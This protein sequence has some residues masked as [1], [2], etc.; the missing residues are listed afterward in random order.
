MTTS[1]SLL[2]PLSFSDLKRLDFQLISGRFRRVFSCFL[3]VFAEFLWISLVKT[4]ISEPFCTAEA[5]ELGRRRLRNGA[6]RWVE[7]A[8]QEHSSIFDELNTDAL[9]LTA[10]IF[11]ELQGTQTAVSSRFAPFFG[12]NAGKNDE[13]RCVFVIFLHVSPHLLPESAI[14]RSTSC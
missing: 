3:M 4:W 5:V 10:M 7:T 11:P 2:G 13:K 14:R 12:S 9:P 1:P 8:G 6:F